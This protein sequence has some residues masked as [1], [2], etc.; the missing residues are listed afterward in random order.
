MHDL[1]QNVMSQNTLKKLK[2]KTSTKK[3]KKRI[4]ISIK[5]DLKKC[6]MTIYKKIKKINNTFT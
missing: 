6:N 3:I 2:I 1:I 5:N 4:Y